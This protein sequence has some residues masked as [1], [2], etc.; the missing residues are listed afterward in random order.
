[1]SVHVVCLM[2]SVCLNFSKIDLFSQNVCWLE[3][4]YTHQCHLICICSVSP[5]FLWFSI[6]IRVSLEIKNNACYIVTRDLLLK[7][8]KDAN[9][10]KKR[11]M[12]RDLKIEPSWRLL[13]TWRMKYLFCIYFPKQRCDKLSYPSNRYVGG[14][15]ASTANIMIQ[16]ERFF[17][18]YL[19]CFT[20]ML[21]W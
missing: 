12:R 21:I 6:R 9:F 14:W 5:I 11:Q 3:I 16:I 19:Y 8:I 20:R 13:F 10:C 17:I 7:I 1:M 15:E 4:C 2:S 18:N